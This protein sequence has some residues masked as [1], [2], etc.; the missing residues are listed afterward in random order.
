MSEEENLWGE[1]PSA[2][3]IETPASI[4]RSQ[5]AVLGRLSDGRLVGQVVST[6]AGQNGLR[7]EFRIVVPALGNY[8]VEIM[9]LQHGAGLYPASVFWTEESGSTMFETAYGSENLKEALRRIFQ[10][11]RVRKIMALLMAQIQAAA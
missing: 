1:L 5:A 7:H 8:A 9:Y 4:L 10:S 2:S 3:P 11:E 6:T